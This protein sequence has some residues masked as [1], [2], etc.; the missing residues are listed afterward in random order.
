MVQIRYNLGCVCAR[1]R[2]DNA[3]FNKVIARVDGQLNRIMLDFE[4]S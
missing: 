1:C 3:N 4:V 2:M